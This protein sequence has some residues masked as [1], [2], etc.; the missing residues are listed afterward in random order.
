MQAPASVHAST[1]MRTCSACRVRVHRDEVHKNRYGQYICKLCRNDGVRAVGL[2]RFQ[3]L[4]H[5][6]PTA[7]LAFLGVVLAMA[8]ATLVVLAVVKA[9][10]Y[11]NAGMV[12]DLKSLVRSI[13]RL[14]H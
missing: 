6:M 11:S 5:R 14:A 10:S 2:R 3:H 12:E 13:N 4:L 7:L 9:H 8:V 1:D